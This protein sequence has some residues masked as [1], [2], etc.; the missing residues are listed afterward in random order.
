MDQVAI[1]GYRVAAPGSEGWAPSAR[2]DRTPLVD[3]DLVAAPEARARAGGTRDAGEL[4]VERL[5]VAGRAFRG[6]AG[7]VAGRHA[8]G[9]LGRDVQLV[10]HLGEPVAL[11]LDGGGTAKLHAH[12]VALEPV[13]LHLLTPGRVAVGA[14]PGELLQV[15]VL[16][17][18]E[19]DSTGV[20]AKG[21][22]ADGVLLTV[23][24]V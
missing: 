11:E 2:L 16:V 20:R 12:G 6:V 7:P 19:V 9:R 21:I 22:E 14:H 18:P 17:P 4:G 5:Q 13:P 3:V 23:L 15:R 10:R 8:S 1:L 24:D